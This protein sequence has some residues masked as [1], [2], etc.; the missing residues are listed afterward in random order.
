MD[1]GGGGANM[2]VVVNDPLFDISGKI[3]VVTGACGL[4]GREIAIAFGSRRARLVLVDVTEAPLE[5]LGIELSNET[6]TMVCDVSDPEKVRRLSS[7]VIA[8]HGHVDVLINC[9]QHKPAG[10]L[11]SNAETCSDELWNAVLGANL[12]GAFYTC[13]E[14]GREMI[15]RRKR[16]IIN[17]ASVYGMVSSNPALYSDNAMGNPVAYSVS[18]GAVGMMTRYLASYWG[19]FGVRVN[20]LTPHGVFR[21]HERA[22][23]DRFSAMVPLKRMMMPGEII[24]ATLFL[25]SEASSFVTGSNV[26][27]DGG[28]TAW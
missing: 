23:I 8:S 27:V 5:A 22:F 13:R 6:R 19:E 2:E 28:W 16:S 18:K 7:D 25:A 14:F 9:H 15:A 11:D 3:I 4:I 26:V 24:G 20:C 17:F 21:D 10:F 1:R 12:N